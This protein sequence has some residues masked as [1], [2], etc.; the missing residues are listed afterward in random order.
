MLT[1]WMDKDKK[2]WCWWW[3]WGWVRVTCKRQDDANSMSDDEDMDDWDVF[4]I[5]F[6]N[7]VEN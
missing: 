6:D 5:G 2:C 4:K 1:D 3:W 7:I